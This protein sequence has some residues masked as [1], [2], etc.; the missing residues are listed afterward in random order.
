M[1][2]NIQQLVDFK[3]ESMYPITLIDALLSDTDGN[4]SGKNALFKSLFGND[5]YTVATSNPTHYYAMSINGAKDINDIVNSKCIAGMASFDGTV[6]NLTGAAY[7]QVSS[8]G[9]FN[10]VSANDSSIGSAGTADHVKSSITFD[11]NGNAG[12][13]VSF[14]GSAAKRI[15]TIHKAVSDTNNNS[16]TSYIYSVSAIS[17]EANKILVKTG[18]E[19]AAA[20]S[21]GTT[22]T[23]NDVAHASAADSATSA[24]SAGSATNSTYAAKLGNSSTPLTAGLVKT[25]SDGTATA[26]ALPANSEDG[27]KV[28]IASKSGSAYTLSWGDGSNLGG[29]GVTL[30]QQENSTTPYYILGTKSTS[31]NT[32]ITDV[33]IGTGSEVGSPFFKGGNLYQTSDETLKHFTE[34]LDVDL[35]N[36]ATIKKGI[37]YWNNDENKILDIGVTAQSVEPLFPEIV[38]ETDGIKSVSYSKLSVV[39][40]AAIDKLY[41]RIKELED[42]ISELK[43]SK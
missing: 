21:Q 15:D 17:G 19:Y 1:A 32:P 25:S 27:T 41:A 20:G 31:D 24:G 28:L 26:Y 23:I 35:D 40:L 18:T 37:F 11:V 9:T 6:T 39:A 42:E 34:D 36:L 30:H 3:Q 5:A 22:I 4:V 8:N 12:S 13:E 10:V 16:L 2:E 38:T 14:D 43:K 29:Q 7:V 33:Y